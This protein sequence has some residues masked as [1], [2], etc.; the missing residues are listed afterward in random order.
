[1]PAW[2]THPQTVDDITQHIVARVLDQF[3]LEHHKARR[4]EGL[5]AAQN[6]SQEKDYGF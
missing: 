2:Y 6:F 4:R 5:Q 1:M 3:G